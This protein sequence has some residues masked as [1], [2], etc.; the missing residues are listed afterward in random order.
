MLYRK[1][2]H[3][4][5]IH[6][7]ILWFP[8]TQLCLLLSFNNRALQSESKR[9]KQNNKKNTCFLRTVY[10][11]VAHSSLGNNYISAGTN[12]DSEKDSDNIVADKKKVAWW[13]YIAKIFHKFYA[14]GCVHYIF[15]SF[16]FKSKRQH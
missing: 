12:C 8:H 2:T 7:N 14:T 11:P 4:K 5:C 9:P 13:S 10:A 15:D 3:Q 16:F 6:H 1:E